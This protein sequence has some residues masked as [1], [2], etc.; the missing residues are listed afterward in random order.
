M[1]MNVY[2]N[3]YTYTYIYIYIHKPRTVNSKSG[4]T[5]PQTLQL[6]TEEGLPAPW[7]SL[8]HLLQRSGP[9]RPSTLLQESLNPEA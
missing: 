4:P 5:R 1:Y 7:T 3:I 6:S 9:Q 8:R 2:I